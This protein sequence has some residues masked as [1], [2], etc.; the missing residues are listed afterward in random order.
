MEKSFLE[1]KGK[2]LKYLF[3]KLLSAW[4]IGYR[5]DPFGIG[6]LP[7]PDKKVPFQKHNL[8]N[9]LLT[10]MAMTRII[11]LRIITAKFL[12]PP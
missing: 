9:S 12:N 2:F 11:N 1:Y 5:K 3:S 4:L 7:K 10:T 6:H 8:N